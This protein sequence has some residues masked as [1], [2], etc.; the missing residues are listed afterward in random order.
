MW[1]APNNHKFGAERE[2]QGPCSL[3][4]FLSGRLDL[5]FITQLHA[6]SRAIDVCIGTPAASV[7]V[8][9]VPCTALSLSYFDRLYNN[10]IIR[11]SGN[12]VKC[13]DEYVDDMVLSDELRKVGATR[14]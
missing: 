4:I 8:E 5:S 7:S 2:I 11:D 12:I 9:S 13:F 10:E 3:F 1:V 14:C 6:A